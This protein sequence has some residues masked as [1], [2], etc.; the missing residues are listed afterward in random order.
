MGCDFSFKAEYGVRCKIPVPSFKERGDVEVHVLGLK[1][2][3]AKGGI[4]DTPLTPDNPPALI[5]IY[6]TIQLGV[7]YGKG[8]AA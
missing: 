1:H 3:L 8:Q 6:K 7:V 2:G 4:H 5:P